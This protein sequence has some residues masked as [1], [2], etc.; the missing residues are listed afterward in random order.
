VLFRNDSLVEAAF[1]RVGPTSSQ[2][3]AEVLRLVQENVD[4]CQLDPIIDETDRVPEPTW[5]TTKELLLA[6]SPS[7]DLSKG[8]AEVKS[9]NLVDPHY[10]EN[11][12]K[13]KERI[14]LAE[15]KAEE[16]ALAAASGD[17]AEADNQ[18]EAEEVAGHNGAA[19][20]QEQV[21]EDE[22]V[23]M[24]GNIP[25]VDEEEPEFDADDPFAEDLPASKR[26]KVTFSDDVP[27]AVPTDDRE[28]QLS[29]LK[30]HLTLLATDEYC[31]LSHRAD[32]SYDEWSVDFESLIQRL[33]EAEIDSVIKDTFGR[34]GH[35][36]VQMMRK[37]G[38]LDERLLPNTALL[39]QRGFRMKLAEMQMAGVV[40]I[41]GIPRDSQHTVNRTIFLWYFDHD[42]V[43]SVFLNNV[44]KVM[45]R[46]FQR[47]EI[48]RQR[49]SE[50]IALSERTDVKDGT[51]KLTEGQMKTLSEFQSKEDKLLGQIARCDSLVGIFRD[52]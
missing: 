26:S 51:E 3:Y 38:K 24:N 32:N 23:T 36:L 2:V 1:E 9:K 14:R 39:N 37:D 27:E 28:T 42:R 34:S 15:A 25:E 12:R 29:Q 44:F 21:N 16:E 48:E 30:N 10:L 40:E 22:D 7:I 35:R 47:L 20:K 46:N 13:K 8:I 4:R 33:R 11:M 6:L 41:Q 18:P 43:S 50:I 17:K 52:Y 31:F 19:Y 5:I 45:S 49:S